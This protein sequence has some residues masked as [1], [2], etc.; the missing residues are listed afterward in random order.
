M[1]ERTVRIPLQIIAIEEEGYHLLVD[2]EINNKKA[3]LLIDSGASRSVFD[4]HRIRKFIGEQAMEPHD[5]LS[6]G[7]GTNSMVTHTTELNNF[8]LGG[9]V[10]PA[11]T[12]VLLD[13]ANVNESYVKLGLSPIDGVLG[14]DLLHQYKAVIDYGSSELHLKNLRSPG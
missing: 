10:L 13:L 5:K 12:A 14:S 7:L 1:R 9:L 6:T 3:L 11:F 2:V 8:Q 4:I